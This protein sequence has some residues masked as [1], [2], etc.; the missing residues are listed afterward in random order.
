MLLV[1]NHF[2]YWENRSSSN[3]CYY[4]SPHLFVDLTQGLLHHSTSVWTMMH[5]F[6]GCCRD[7][8]LNH[9]QSCFPG[10]P[11]CTEGAWDKI[12][13][14]RII[15]AS[16]GDERAAD[17]K[18][19]DRFRV[20]HENRHLW[21]FPFLPR[22]GRSAVAASCCRRACPSCQCRGWPEPTHRRS[23]SSRSSCSVIY[24]PFSIS[25]VDFGT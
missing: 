20:R 14:S 17:E 22:F 15:F 24:C 3:G 23:F 8:W 12:D 5:H 7:R 4:Y 13:S 2:L 16:D 21:T 11:P 19:R 9:F 18:W 25:C 6:V 1:R 10:Y